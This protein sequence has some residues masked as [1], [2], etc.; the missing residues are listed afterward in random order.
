MN[1]VTLYETSLFSSSRPQDL[2]AFFRVLLVY[3]IVR[4]VYTQGQ[5]IPNSTY[6]EYN[7]YK[8]TGKVSS[9]V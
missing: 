6:T 4:R 8:K 2:A 9:L 1:D 5:N 3:T 7:R